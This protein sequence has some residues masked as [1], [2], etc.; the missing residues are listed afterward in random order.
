MNIDGKCI[1]GYIDYADKL[2]KQDWKPI[3]A[4]KYLV[5]DMKTL[6]QKQ[7]QLP[8]EAFERFLELY[9]TTNKT[10]IHHYTPTGVFQVG[11]EKTAHMREIKW[12]FTT[13]MLLSQVEGN[14]GK[15]RRITIR[16]ASSFTVFTRF[17]SRRLLRDLKKSL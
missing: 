2:S 11:R 4:G 12:Y 7:Q 8:V 16:I 10:W 9:V 3:F 6:D 13:I 1:S 14:D 17:G 15:T 5:C